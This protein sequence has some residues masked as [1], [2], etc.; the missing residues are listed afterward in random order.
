MFIVTN[1]ASRAESLTI[2]PA[3]VAAAPVTNTPGCPPNSPALACT[4]PISPMATA[5]V[6]VDLSTGAYT[7]TTT[8]SGGT[9][10]A[11]ATAPP[12]QSAQLHIGTSRPSS[13]GQLLIP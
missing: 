7:V 13:S 12:I 11:A 4:G 6:K 9:E 10:A 5:Q 1:Q 8:G 3:G 2:L